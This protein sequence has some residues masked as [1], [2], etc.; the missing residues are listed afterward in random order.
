MK[1][2][3]ELEKSPQQFSVKVVSAPAACRGQLSS[4]SDDI[5]I[6]AVIRKR[7]T[8]DKSEEETK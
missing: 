4:D 2:S 6:K 7:Q 3:V 5:K 8:D 1:K